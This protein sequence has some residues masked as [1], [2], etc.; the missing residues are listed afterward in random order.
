[1]GKRT[2]SIYEKETYINNKQEKG[3]RKM[4]VRR[5][6]KGGD[7]LNG[8]AVGVGWH[9]QGAGGGCVSRLVRVV[10]EVLRQVSVTRDCGGFYTK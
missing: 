1:M 5:E 7:L 4:C 8:K 10:R 6:C 2:E 3:K 9:G